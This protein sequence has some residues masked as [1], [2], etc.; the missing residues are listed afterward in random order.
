MKKM[1]NSVVWVVMPRDG[2]NFQAASKF[3]KLRQLFNGN[4]SP[5]NLKALY[6]EAK[7]CFQKYSTKNDWLIMVGPLT[8]C[9]AAAVAFSEVWG[10]LPLLVY[11]ASMKQYLQREIE[12][13]PAE[14]ESA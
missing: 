4:I 14:I 11:H 10:K 1:K 6:A 7:E 2:M 12:L 3:G 13:K 8:A 5:L 9:S